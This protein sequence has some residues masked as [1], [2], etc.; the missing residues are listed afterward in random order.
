MH[1]EVN[2]IDIENYEIGILKGQSSQQSM[3]FIMLFVIF[4][5]PREI[6]NMDM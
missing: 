3:P 6:C 4:V 2:A 5:I 1:I